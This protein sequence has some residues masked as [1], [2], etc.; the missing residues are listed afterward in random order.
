MITS[1]LVNKYVSW[2]DNYVN[3]FIKQFPDLAENIE[4]KAKLNVYQPSIDD[5][6]ALD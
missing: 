5:N 6:R 4:I 2:F 1:E 3:Q